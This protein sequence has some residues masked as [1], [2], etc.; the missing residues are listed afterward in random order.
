VFIKNT[1]TQENI[2]IFFKFIFPQNYPQYPPYIVISK[3][4]KYD[5]ADVPYL[6][7]FQ[8]T[9]PILKSWNQINTNSKVLIQIMTE[10]NNLFNMNPPLRP[11]N[12]AYNI[13][14]L[15]KPGQTGPLIQGPSIVVPFELESEEML[16]LKLMEYRKNN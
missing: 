9:P 1:I 8:V 4:D 13:N 16:K 12:N 5:Y 3:P 2:G 11:S 14:P 6:N 7:Q 10:I 15:L